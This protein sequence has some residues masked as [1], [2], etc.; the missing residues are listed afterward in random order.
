MVSPGEKG[1][2]VAVIL[3]QAARREK[4]ER[5]LGR[6][7]RSSG[8]V[9]AGG[10]VHTLWVHHQPRE[11]KMMTHRRVAPLLASLAAGGLAACGGLDRADLRDVA[12]PPQVYAQAL[13]PGFISERD[14]AFL[15]EV[16]GDVTEATELSKV[17]LQR[18]KSANV[19]QFA[20]QE[21]DAQT[22]VHEDL[23]SLATTRRIN[24]S[25][26]MDEDGVTQLSTLREIPEADLD[27]QY[28]KFQVENHEDSVALYSEAAQSADD[29]ELR[30]WADHGVAMLKEHLAQASS[31]L[32]GLGNATTGE[33]SS[34]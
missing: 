25:G 17:L 34:P 18:S 20:Q 9:A 32:D 19:K 33:G 16:A 5:P 11:D 27:R 21:V 13:A 2:R 31:L 4:P 7:P 23:V 15:A 14:K 12:T 8:S 30:A 26:E 6:A 10:I 28:L 22:L 29:V 24:L 3:P 1:E